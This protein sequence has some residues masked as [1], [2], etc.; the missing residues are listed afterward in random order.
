MLG[1][2]TLSEAVISL[3]I[4]NAVILGSPIISS[5]SY[6]A[7]FI[8]MRSWSFYSFKKVYEI[9]RTKIILKSSG[10]GK[11]TLLYWQPTPLSIIAISS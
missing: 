6:N 2:V 7:H 11:E 4:A 3:Q 5:F 10:E 1:I 8:L 9:Q